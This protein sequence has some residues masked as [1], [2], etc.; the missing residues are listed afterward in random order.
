MKGAK[1][2]TVQFKNSIFDEVQKRFQ[3]IARN[4]FL[5]KST[6]SISSTLQSINWNGDLDQ[7]YDLSLNILNKKKD[8]LIRL[9]LLSYYVPKEL[10]FYLKLA[11]EEIVKN[12]CI[13]NSEIR[14]ILKS[15]QNKD[16]WLQ[17]FLGSKT[18]NQIFGNFFN[19]NDWIETFKSLR[20]KKKR[21]H[22]LKS[23]YVPEK[24][25]IGVGYRD[26][27]TLPKSTSP[28]SLRD[29]TLTSL[30]NKIYE[31]R[32]KTDDLDKILEGF[33]W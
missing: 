25:T 1:T 28:G 5:A 24:R 4:D 30:Q 26:K 17:S 23:D 32:D 14:F 31:N 3:Q 9:S 27:G 8:N 15:E 20:I 10:G 6:V 22:K 18:G 29:L 13:E 19:N 7:H 11:L 16:L 21:N 2:L 12:P 33:F